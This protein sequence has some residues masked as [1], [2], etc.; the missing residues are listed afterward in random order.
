MQIYFGCLCFLFL[1]GCVSAPL[2]AVRGSPQELFVHACEPGKNIRAVQG[3]VWLKTQS[4]EIS[5]QFPV[6]V[7]ATIPD[8]LNLEVTNVLG[9]T[10]ALI[11]LKGDYYLV[12][13]ADKKDEKAEKRSEGWGRWGGIPLKWATVLFLGKIPCPNP[14]TD[15]RLLKTDNGGIRVTLPAK[16]TH[17]SQ[18]FVYSFRNW[19]NQPWPES[20]H[21]E[22]G[23]GQGPSVDFKFDEP[24]EGT[25][26]PKKWEARSVR[27]AVKVRW[28]DREV[29]LGS[30]Y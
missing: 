10:E 26:S 17:L 30:Q 21:W 12:T 6:N 1:S 16:G 29:S 25:L 19:K 24:D 15:L 7:M 22:E 23:E 18:V 3:A 14:S 9:G 28:R 4:D 5:G 11:T 13:G 27:G 20:L 2:V 8:Q